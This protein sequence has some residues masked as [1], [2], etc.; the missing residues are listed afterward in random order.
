MQEERSLDTGAGCMRGIKV[1]RLKRRIGLERCNK[2]RG[3]E[4]ALAVN[5]LMQVKCIGPVQ[6]LEVRV[7]KRIQRLNL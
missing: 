5:G 7:K 6:S 3:S 2:R 4:V 1:S